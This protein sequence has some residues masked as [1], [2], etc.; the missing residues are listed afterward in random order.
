MSI[1]ARL[2]AFGL[3]TDLKLPTKLTF[4]VASSAA[5]RRLLTLVPAFGLPTDLKLPTKLTV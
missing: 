3:P 1:G 2:P 5:S 4:L